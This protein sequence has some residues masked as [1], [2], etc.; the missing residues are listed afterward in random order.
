[1]V[2]VRVSRSPIVKREIQ[3]MLGDINLSTRNIYKVKKI[4]YD[5]SS[6]FHMWKGNFHILG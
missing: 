1:M 6:M 5:T 2:H 4:T 3:N